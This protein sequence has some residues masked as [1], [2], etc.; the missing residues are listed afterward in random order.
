MFGGDGPIVGS[1]D[2]FATGN[3]DTGSVPMW[4]HFMFNTVFCATAA[5]IVSGAMAERTKFKSYLVYSVVI[6]AV[7][8]P[9]EAHWTWV[10]AGYHSSASVLGQVVSQ[11]MQVLLLYIW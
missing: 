4:V 5:T 10:V 9:I 3:Y 6:S 1:F 11:T 2:L 7:I 8:Y